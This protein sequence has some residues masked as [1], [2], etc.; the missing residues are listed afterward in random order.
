MDHQRAGNVWKLHNTVSGSLA[1]IHSREFIDALRNERKERGYG[2][3]PL[4]GAGLSATSGIPIVKEL[5]LYLQRCI[6]LALGV[7][8]LDHEEQ[9]DNRRRWNPRRD[10]WPPLSDPRRPQDID[11]FLK[12]YAE[13]QMRKQAGIYDPEL[14][15]F[16]EALGALAE[17]R[18]SL[19][20][21]SRLDNEPYGLDRRE[22]LFLNS[23]EASVVDKFFR[24]VTGGRRPTLAH[25][26]LAHLSP[27]LG[28]E[29]ILTT[30]FDKLLENAFA[31][32]SAALPVHPVSLGGTLPRL[33]DLVTHPCLVKM[34]GSENHLRGD[35]TLDAPPTAEDTANFVSYLLG[36]QLLGDEDKTNNRSQPFRNHLLVVGFSA[37]DRRVR[38]LIGRAWRSLPSDFKVFWLCYRNEDVDQVKTFA[39]EVLK[40]LPR[41]IESNQEQCQIL[42]HTDYGLLFLEMFQVITRSL[43][44]SG[45]IFPSVSRLPIP[46]QLVSAPDPNEVQQNEPAQ[47]KAA[48]R[49]R[50]DAVQHRL[51]VGDRLVV[52]TSVRRGP[53][54]RGSADGTAAR[55]AADMLP[56]AESWP[57]EVHGLTSVAAEVFNELQADGQTC[58][59]LDMNDIVSTDDL[60]EQLL[61]AVCYRAGVEDWMPV[62]LQE[63][64]LS[65]AQEIRRV[66]QPTGRNWVLFLNARETPGLNF[67]NESELA[68]D[69]IPNGW[70]DHHR[71]DCGRSGNDRDETDSSDDSA[72]VESFLD[73]LHELCGPQCPNLVVV[74]LCRK[75]KGLYEILRVK[76]KDAVKSG[77]PPS[78]W[79]KFTSTDDNT[80]GETVNNVREWANL[81]Q[82]RRTPFLHTL[83]L[84]Q[85]TRYASAFWSEPF[86]TRTGAKLEEKE[87]REW[88]QKL[89]ELNILRTK[90]G[91]FVWLHT[92]TREALRKDIDGLLSPDEGASIHEGLAHW[93]HQVFLR[94]NSP[95][96]ILE[97]VHHSCEATRFCLLA[98]PPAIRRAIE[99][100]RWADT[101]LDG[102]A[103]HIR[104]RGFSRGSCRRLKYIREKYAG[105]IDPK[106]QTKRSDAVV[107][108]IT[109]SDLLEAIKDIQARCLIVMRGVA[110][111]MGEQVT[112]FA[113]HRQLCELMVRGK[114][115]LTLNRKVDALQQPVGD[116][117]ANVDPASGIMKAFNEMA[118]DPKFHRQIQWMKWWRWLATL[119]K[120][121]RSHYWAE[122]AL[123]KILTALAGPALPAAT[124]VI[125]PKDKEQSPPHSPEEAKAG[126]DF[127]LGRVYENLVRDSPLVFDAAPLEIH[128]HPFQ[129]R[130]EVAKTLQEY[131]EV[132]L[133]YDNVERRR[134]NNHQNL[135]W[136]A[137]KI[138]YKRALAILKLLQS[139]EERDGTQQQIIWLRLRLET[140][141]SIVF[142]EPND[143]D[144]SPL[145]HINEAEVS[146]LRVDLQHSSVDWAI[147]D[148]HRGEFA[149]QRALSR[150]KKHGR[151]FGDR[152]GDLRGLE[153]VPE[154]DLGKMLDN[155]LEQV[156]R[157][158]V[159]A[160]LRDAESCLD[161]AEA[162]LL[163]QR[164][165]VFWATWYFQRRMRVI[166]LELWATVGDRPKD[167]SDDHPPLPIPHLGLEAAP[168]RTPTLADELLENAIRM[169]RLDVYR[170]ATIV[171]CYSQCVLALHLR[172]L[173]DPRLERLP[174]RQK[175]MRMRLSKALEQLDK[176]QGM[177]QVAAAGKP[178]SHDDVRVNLNPPP[179]TS[180][181]RHQVHDDVLEYIKQVK[182]TVQNV[183]AKTVNAHH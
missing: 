8:V 76:G 141:C 56:S 107:P 67:Q 80:I 131:V 142:Q 176:I 46:P 173:N 115:D 147:L 37:A 135:Y 28:F 106:P 75:S 31:Q 111:E 146:L 179:L 50:I 86:S 133:L 79:I 114:V 60:F 13:W 140:A 77:F 48:L 38:H 17:W 7:D 158:A 137:V 11:W 159:I 33:A 87:I 102:A 24:H 15:V 171:E 14:S 170:F 118:R 18:T 72:C 22:A 157:S 29:T 104:T 64:S 175:A 110:H 91:G 154:G 164:K 130:I 53:Q 153:D 39:E 70:L 139:T 128:I 117:V 148:L 89:E 99:H 178:R 165:N 27:V 167:P 63:D 121:S 181:G 73:L 55:P 2:F 78:T 92:P 30:N 150:G 123:L 177:R 162:V 68:L 105:F 122:K 66:T 12:V 41:A 69:D 124:P 52:A 119:E 125:P 138:C 126:L 84:M 120:A 3:I 109:D 58:V 21:L 96:S 49:K 43:P 155:L 161:R 65:R 112:A 100:V 103:G 182:K 47:V 74:L 1:G 4:I 101:Q 169:V 19:L 108:R 132:L 36:R 59:W 134:G 71:A 16:Q 61:D 94:S 45:I 6:G 54:P 156:D 90:T 25:R 129:I 81:D 168:R 34:H 166:E 151:N 174:L 40:P 127:L 5:A 83:V 93:Y 172:L 95:F 85:R 144:T 20:F 44:T 163:T 62:R 145:K 35:Y 26:M 113:R 152:V 10:K 143:E 160:A 9:K 136:D 88:L 149:I 51:F 98:N 57:V 32:T 97:A 42:R 23:P 82:V 116:G 180:A 183:L